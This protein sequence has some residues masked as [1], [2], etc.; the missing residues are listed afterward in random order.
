M[1][2]GLQEAGNVVSANGYVEASEFLS[3]RAEPSPFRLRTVE[4][5]ER[6]STL[7]G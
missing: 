2:R 6:P 5:L 4:P 1:A 3:Q 7:S